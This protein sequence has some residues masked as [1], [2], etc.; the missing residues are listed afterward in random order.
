V[1]RESTR[2]VGGDPPDGRVGGSWRVLGVGARSQGRERG[3][4][5]RENKHW[6][7]PF[8]AMSNFVS[9]SWERRICF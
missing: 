7:N 2:T 8:K 1:E 3:G 5:R 9:R 4:G 6:S